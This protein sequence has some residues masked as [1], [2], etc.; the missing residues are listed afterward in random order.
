MGAIWPHSSFSQR[1]RLAGQ[2]RSLPKIGSKG[3]T[4]GSICRAAVGLVGLLFVLSRVEL[5]GFAA[6]RQPAELRRKLLLAGF[7]GVGGMLLHPTLASAADE[8]ATTEDLKKHVQL[9]PSVSFDLPANEEFE[10][11]K[12]ENADPQRVALFTKSDGTTVAVGPI[13][14]EF[15]S[16]VKNAAEQPGGEKTTGIKLL[17]YEV[18]K[19]REPQAK[20]EDLECHETGI[21]ASEAEERAS[22]EKQGTLEALKPLAALM[23]QSLSSNAHYWM[24]ALHSKLGSQLMVIALPEEKVWEEQ[25]AMKAVLDS[26]AVDA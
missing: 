6:P 4:C 15:L 16:N 5:L 9:R 20:V 1:L 17:R 7:S 24:R 8:K 23:P 22:A 19:R 10:N 12:V 13:Y 3:S 25:L 18:R 2:R 14:P 26:F 11:H 21:C